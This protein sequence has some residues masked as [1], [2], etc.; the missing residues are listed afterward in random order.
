MWGKNQ[1]QKGVNMNAAKIDTLIGKNTVV[2]G[3]VL[4]AG[5]LHV[6]G[7]IIGNIT[8]EDEGGVLI[9]SEN[10][11]VEGEVHVPNMVLNGL[12]EGDVHASQRV[13]LAPK[14]RVHGNVYYNLIEM[15]MGAEVNGSLV[16]RKGGKP[17]LEFKGPAPDG[18]KTGGA[19]STSPR[20][21]KSGKE[22]GSESTAKAAT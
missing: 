1:G 13:E 9:L 12:I 21:G 4:F 6:E 11:V 15:A 3:D 14:S 20:A 5:G 18:A 2:K 16:H 17:Q 8:A 19:E 7:K 10:G 22:S